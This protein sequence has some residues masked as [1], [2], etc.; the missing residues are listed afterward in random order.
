MFFVLKEI[1]FFIEAIAI[2]VSYIHVCIYNRFLYIIE[3]DNIFIYTTVVA[4]FVFMYLGKVFIEKINK[5]HMSW[6][7]FSAWMAFIVTVT[8]DLSYRTYN[9]IQN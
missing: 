5:K 7:F 4:C 6:Q 2:E 9:Y 8:Y 3:K 1:I